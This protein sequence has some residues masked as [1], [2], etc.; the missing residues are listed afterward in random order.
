MSE[1]L[2]ANCIWL[3]EDDSPFGVRCLDCRPFTYQVARD[4][5]G[6]VVVERFQK[7]RG[8]QGAA[9]SVGVQ[10]N[11]MGVASHLSYSYEG[12]PDDEMLFAPSG[13]EDKWVI[14]L[15]GDCLCFARSWTRA[16]IYRAKV[17][18]SDD[19]MDLVLIDADIE[20][21]FGDPE[22]AVRQVDYLIASH[23][24]QVVVPHPLPDGFPDDIREIVT[25]SF[26]QY[27]RRA[28]YATYADTTL[29][30]RA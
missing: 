3:E 16:M 25:F 9:K 13:M 23:L 1:D 5:S 29:I 20:A 24:G 8:V 14:Y 21:S 22:F 7:L 11:R 18:F 10:G 28:W 30:A 12:L 4:S 2:F 27:G 15:E 6:P 26:G 17:S 19:Q